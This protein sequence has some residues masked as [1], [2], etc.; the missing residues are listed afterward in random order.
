AL[1][2]TTGANALPL[3]PNGTQPAAGLGGGAMLPGE[4]RIIF[5]V[6]ESPFDAPD[7]RGVTRLA[8]ARARF[9]DEKRLK[10]PANGEMTLPREAFKPA[11]QFNPAV[12]C[13]DP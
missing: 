9:N 6:A 5:E 10:D 3:A 4:N 13:V 7:E 2:S 1:A 12:D 11:D 8:C